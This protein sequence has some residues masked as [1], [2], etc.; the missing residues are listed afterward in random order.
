[1]RA[2][3]VK[4][5]DAAS[6]CGSVTSVSA[7]G[8]TAAAAVTEVRG[9]GAGGAGGVTARL[10]L[11][12]MTPQDAAAGCLPTGNGAGWGCALAPSQ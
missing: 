6:T 3:L 11:A 10:L 9:L 5:E 2:S 7:T 8:P 1:M 4:T 12:V